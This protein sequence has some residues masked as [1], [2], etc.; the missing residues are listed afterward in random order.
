MLPKYFLYYPWIFNGIFALS[1]RNN[2]NYYC[3]EDHSGQSHL[4]YLQ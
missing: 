1:C 4:L 3:L 2:I